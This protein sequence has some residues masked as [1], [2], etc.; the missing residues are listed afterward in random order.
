MYG[1]IGYLYEHKHSILEFTACYCGKEKRSVVC[2]SE[3]AGSLNFLCDGICEKTLGC[4]NHQCKEKCHSGD[5]SPCELIV[6]AVL[7]C[8]CGKVSRFLFI[9][10]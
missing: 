7:T 2:T 6:S 9:V 1:S 10:G 5:C 8:P 4:G 3:H